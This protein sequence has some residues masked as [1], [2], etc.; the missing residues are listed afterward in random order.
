MN[1]SEY[2]NPTERVAKEMYARD[3]LA[4]MLG[5]R[6]TETDTGF[7]QAQI[8]VRADMLN[9]F[10]IC[11]GGIIFALADTAFAYA[12]NG[13]NKATVAMNCSISYLKPCHEG[14]VLIATARERVRDGRNGIF[15]VTVRGA[16]KQIIAIFQGNSREIR[17]NSVPGLI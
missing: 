10:E 4:N 11:H 1:N 5:I 6:I 12:C 17:G 7:A 2:N 14:E 3:N 16:D 8:L 13:N 9:S 15:D